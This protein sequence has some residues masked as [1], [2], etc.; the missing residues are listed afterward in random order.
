MAS[1]GGF[2]DRAGLVFPGDGHP[3]DSVPYDDSSDP[4]SSVSDPDNWNWIDLLQY[5]IQTQLDGRVAGVGNL[6]SRPAA[7]S[8]AEKFWIVTDG[9]DSGD[10]PYLTYNDDSEWHIA[11]HPGLVVAID[12]TDSPYS[13]SPGE[14][15][16]VDASNGAVTIDL[17][18]PAD[19]GS[20]F[21]VKV[22][23]ATND[24][25]L[26]RNGT[27]NIDGDASDLVISAADVARSLVPDG[28]D[29]WVI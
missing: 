19:A 28:T 12:D 17:F 15:V 5:L 7:G 23:D 29:W 3:G 8:S 25:T 14:T 2:S 20:R 16:L 21:D 6:A 4:P 18:D 22:K 13:V 27:E 10:Q 24:T 11:G 9:G 1:D 26:S